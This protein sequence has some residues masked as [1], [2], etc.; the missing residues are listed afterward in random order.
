[1]NR[2]SG[3]FIAALLL[4]LAGAYLGLV[5]G[6]GEWPGATS[7]RQRFAAGVEIGY[8]VMALVSVILLWMGHPRTM[9]AV[10]LWA[11]LITI[12]GG[13]AP[14]FWGGASLKIGLLSALASGIVAVLVVWVASRALRSR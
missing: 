3:W 11:V 13:I 4:L 7:A 14:V 10:W 6:P 12:T 1:M 8:G 2:R 9:V 5:N